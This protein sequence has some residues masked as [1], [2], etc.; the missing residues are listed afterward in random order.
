M[1]ENELNIVITG[2]INS[3]KTSVALSI[4]EALAA[5][6]IAVE[7]LDPD[8]SYKSWIE[9]QGTKVSACLETLSKKGLRVTV[10]TKQVRC[11]RDREG[12]MKR[13]TPPTLTGLLPNAAKD[14]LSSFFFER[15]RESPLNWKSNPTYTYLDACDDCQFQVGDYLYSIMHECFESALARFNKEHPLRWDNEAQKSFRVGL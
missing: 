8:I 6:G 11:D 14:A 13:R 10:E 3:G 1:K 5:H 15:L 9:D 12:S 7:V 4:K 2:G